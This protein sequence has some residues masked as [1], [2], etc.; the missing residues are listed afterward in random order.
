MEASRQLSDKLTEPVGDAPA[1][2]DT[3]DVLAEPETLD[4]DAIEG[5]MILP[6]AFS[7]SPP[8]PPRL[9][10]FESSRSATLPP[11][12]TLVTSPPSKSA[13]SQAVAPV[14]PTGPMAVTEPTAEDL[15]AEGQLAS[16]RSSA[17][18]SSDSFHT[19]P[20][21]HSPITPLPP[22]PPPSDPASPENYPYP[23]DNIQYPKRSAHHRDKSDNTITAD[24]QFILGPLSSSDAEETV[25]STTTSM[26]AEPPTPD[27]ES[28]AEDKD[29]G[30]EDTVKVTGIETAT[31][32]AVHRPAYRHRATTS[33]IS[34]RQRALSPLP[35][36][37]NLI[38]PQRQRQSRPQLPPRPRT[39]P[40]RLALV[41]RLPL[42]VIHKTCEILLSPPGHLIGLMLRV[43]ARIA[44]GEWRGFVSGQGDRGEE[45]AVSW[46]YSSEEGSRRTSEDWDVIGREVAD[47]NREEH[48]VEGE[49][50]AN[51]NSGEGLTKLKAG[52]KA[53]LTKHAPDEDPDWSKSW[54]VD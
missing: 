25:Q 23:H 42:A 48:A 7:H 17:T 5:D 46:D 14:Q 18:D 20:S 4:I 51:T 19:V 38:T 26:S 32:T 24:T 3:S 52:P 43:A 35:P 36:A 53:V 2:D 31:K 44:A 22:S 54:G 45:M 27:F 28:A 6:E 29:S 39:D 50:L 13:V 8:I 21:W 33:S 47:D 34:V 10:R 11:H 41:R 30:Q 1:A 49:R 16:R 37:V 9:A 15:Q 12:L 40:S